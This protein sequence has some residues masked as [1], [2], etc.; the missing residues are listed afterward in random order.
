VRQQAAAFKRLPARV[1]WKLSAAEVEALHAP[2]EPGLGDNIKARRGLRVRV[3][4][5]VVPHLHDRLPVRVE[6]ERGR[7]GG[8]ACAWRARRRRQHQG[9][10][11][12]GVSGLWSG[13]RIITGCLCGPAAF[14]RA[15][16]RMLG[17]RLGGRGAA[18]SAP[19]VRRRMGSRS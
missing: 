11:R 12:P 19:G 2:G 15:G 3:R 6:A 4:A 10:A 18:G 5:R 8:A 13:P 1:L 16:A 14:A 7:G 17:R 9:A